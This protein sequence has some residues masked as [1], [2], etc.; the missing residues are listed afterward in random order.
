MDYIPI[1]SAKVKKAFFSKVAHDGEQNWDLL[2]PVYFLIP[3]SD[4]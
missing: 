1:T 3:Q 2:V 4:G